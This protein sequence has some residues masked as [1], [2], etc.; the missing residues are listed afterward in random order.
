MRITHLYRYPVKGLSAEPLTQVRLE[1]GH[2]LP[3]DR[4]FALALGGTS[5]D[6]ARPAWQPKNRFMCQMKHASI[7]ALTCR[8]TPETGQMVIASA[9]DRIAANA[10]TQAGR[11]AIGDWLTAYLG[12]AASCSPRSATLTL[13]FMRK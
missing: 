4:A 2:A 7:A 1:P 6:T 13:G 12:P 9:E 5:F 3:W 8:F 11:A 10:L